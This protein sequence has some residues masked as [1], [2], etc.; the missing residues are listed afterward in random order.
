MIMV[1]I[2]QKLVRIVRAMKYFIGQR[3]RK[4]D[5]PGSEVCNM[6]EC[7]IHITVLHTYGVYL[8]RIQCHSEENPCNRP[9]LNLLSVDN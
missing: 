8:Y 4:F 9:S 5:K 7:A 2:L 1:D 3:T 6:Q